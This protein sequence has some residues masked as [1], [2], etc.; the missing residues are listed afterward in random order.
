VWAD[1]IGSSAGMTKDVFA[2]FDLLSG[3]RT[4]GASSQGATVLRTLIDFAWLINEAHVFADTMTL[5]LV[6]GTK[7]VADAPDPVSEPY[8]D[9]AFLHTLHSGELGTSGV[10]ADTPC[11]VHYD[12]HSMRKVD[13]VGETWLLVAE[14]GGTGTLTYDIHFRVRTLLLLP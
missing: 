3:Y 13:E 9:W 8:A 4:A 10:T 7:T 14:G 6:V 2:A 11:A 1:Q 5:G 12:V